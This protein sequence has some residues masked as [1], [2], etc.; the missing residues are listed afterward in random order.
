M[1]CK[2]G[3]LLLTIPRGWVPEVST[4]NLNEQSYNSDF[5]KLT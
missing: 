4:H 3:F 5:L 1:Q 2:V